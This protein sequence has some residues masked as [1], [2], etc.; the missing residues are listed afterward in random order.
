MLGGADFEMEDPGDKGHGRVLWTDYEYSVVYEC[1][2]TLDDGGC[3]PNQ[4]I[5]AVYGRERDL[6]DDLLE[7]VEPAVTK[8]FT[9][10]DIEKVS[11]QGSHNLHII[12]HISIV[13]LEK[14]LPVQNHQFSQSVP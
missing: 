10:E 5:I 8:C 3:Q 6:P 13:S 2:R 9:K 14:E 12:N 1:A 11:Q 7:K 4:A